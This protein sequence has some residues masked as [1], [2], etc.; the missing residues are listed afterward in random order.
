MCVDCTFRNVERRL[1]DKIL[2]FCERTKEEQ[3]QQLEIKKETKRWPRMSLNYQ[4][5]S[6]RIKLLPTNKINSFLYKFLL[7]HCQ[8]LNQLVFDLFLV[9]V[10]YFR[11]RE[12]GLVIH[13]NTSVVKLLYLRSWI[14]SSIDNF[15]TCTVYPCMIFLSLNLGYLPIHTYT[16]L[17]I[18]IDGSIFVWISCLRF[19][20]LVPYEVFVCLF[21]SVTFLHIISGNP[22]FKDN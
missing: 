18:V 1:L 7:S 9:L 11:S 14:I 4:K 17:I 10:M 8:R 6:I 12:R 15:S 20:L 16:H 13:G 22:S 21:F 3:R 5:F 19:D 2:M